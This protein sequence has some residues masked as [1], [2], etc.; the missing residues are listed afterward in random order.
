MTVLV[1]HISGESIQFVM[2]LPVNIGN[3]GMTSA[4]KAQAALTILTRKAWLGLLGV[5]EVDS[6]EKTLS[7]ITEQQSADEAMLA[8]AKAKLSAAQSYAEAL[9]VYKSAKATGKLG[10]ESLASLVRLGTEIKDKL[11]S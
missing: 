9:A 11:G 6:Y 7:A 5:V 8:E 2:S 1:T 10:E 3:K 4:D